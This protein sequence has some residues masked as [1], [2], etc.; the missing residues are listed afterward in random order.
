MTVTKA[1]WRGPTPWEP[2]MGANLKDSTKK[3]DF[4][5]ATITHKMT[6]T[7]RFLKDH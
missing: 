6:I 4:C 1:G 5:R 7:G 2:S 3:E